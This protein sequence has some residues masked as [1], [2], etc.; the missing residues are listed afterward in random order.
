MATISVITPTVREELMPIVAKSLE[1]QTLKDFEW[2]IVTPFPE[3][4][5][6]YN[7]K[8]IKEPPKRKGDYYSLNKAWNEAFRHAKGSLIINIV[9]G[10]WFP[11]NTLERLLSHH[12]IDSKAC[13]TCVGCQYVE[14]KNDKPEG[15]VWRDPR[16]RLD[17]GTF[18]EVGHLEM[19]LCLAAFPRQA[20]YDVGGIDEKFDKYAA[21][22]EKEMM[23]RMEQAGYKMYINQDIEYRALKHDRLSKE[24]DNK[25][26]EAQT[27]YNSVV[28][29]ILKGK[30]IK[31]DYLQ[32]SDKMVRKVESEKEKPAN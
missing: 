31:L 32:E 18:Y 15:L 10:I 16:M 25:Y 29:D 9:D 28:P 23:L 4:F 24:W 26:L 19:E 22:S 11:P 2:I 12:Q 3:K 20:V 8:V 27:Y 14:I 17:M 21:L 13:I 30:R 1:K 5:K 6:G 7:A